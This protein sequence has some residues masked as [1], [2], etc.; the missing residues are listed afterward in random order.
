MSD[1]RI[2]TNKKSSENKEINISSQTEQNTVEII[3]NS[4]NQENNNKNIIFT[5][6]KY[7]IF[8]Y[9]SKGEP[10]FLIGPD[11]SYFI[12]MLIMN[13]IYFTFFNYLFITITKFYIA[14]IGIILNF[15]QLLF[16]ILACIKNPGLPRKELQNE[17]LLINEP[18]KYKR[19]QSCSFIIDKTKNYYHC[20]ICECCC[21]GYDHHCPWT[22]KCVGKRNIFYFNGMLFMISTIFIYVIFAFVISK[23]K[24]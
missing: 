23:P 10:L 12:S 2:K 3:T 15:L 14:I 18:N 21:E 16:F 6:G 5:Y 9:D 17:L 7:K 4:I 1:D 20:V 22:S 19:C 13:L 24:K 8:L 11:Y